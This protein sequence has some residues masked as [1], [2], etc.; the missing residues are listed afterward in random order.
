MFIPAWMLD[1]TVALME[2]KEGYFIYHIGLQNTIDEGVKRFNKHLKDQ[3][4]ILIEEPIMVDYF[5]WNGNIMYVILFKSL[6]NLEYL[7]YMSDKTSR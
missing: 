6:S 5:N 2:F 7:E 4:Q 1:D 3:N